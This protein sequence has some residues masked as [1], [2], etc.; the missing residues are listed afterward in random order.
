[1]VGDNIC[2]PG[3]DGNRHGPPTHP[4]CDADAGASREGVPLK[5]GAGAETAAAMG[6]AGKGAAN[7]CGA[8]AGRA[9]GGA[10]EA[11]PG[12]ACDGHVAALMARRARST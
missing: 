5:W 7:G 12:W 6:F 10:P 3:M 1:M 4:A 9:N 2:A 11:V 8:G